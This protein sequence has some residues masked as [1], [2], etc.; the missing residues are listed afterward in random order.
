VFR[1]NVSAIYMS[2]N[3][4]HH[5]RMKHIVL[6]IHFVWDKVSLG[7]VRVLHVPSSGQFA[8]VFTKGH[9]STLFME[10]Q[11]RLRQLQRR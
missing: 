7:E 2:R 4:V 6:D 5:K 3:L 9:P 10:F 1:D 11:N 8:D